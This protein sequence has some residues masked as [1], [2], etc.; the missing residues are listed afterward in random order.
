[1]DTTISE[2]AKPGPAQSVAT[3]EVTIE[4]KKRSEARYANYVLCVLMVVG[5]LN[6]LDRQI[7]SILIEDIKMDLG[8]SDGDMG[9]L[10]GTA[11]AVFY[12]T[13]GMALARLADV[14]NRKKLI[15]IG[16]GVWSVMT[17]LT[18]LAQNFTTLAV[19]RFGVGVGESCATPSSFSILYDCFPAKV[20]TT[21][22]GI[23]SCGPIVGGALGI[24]L[25]GT[26][27]DAWNGTWP[28]KNLAPLSLVGW[29]AALVIVGLPGVLVSFWVSTLREPVRGRYDGIVS[30]NHPHPFREA[31]IV[32]MSMLPICNLILLLKMGKGWRDIALNLVF[33]LLVLVGTYHLTMLTENV[34]QCAGL[35]IGFY[36]VFSWIQNLAAR[37]AVIFALIFRCKTTI[38][39]ILGMVT[40][41]LMMG[42][43]FWGV[44]FLQ[45]YHGASA[46][47]VGS[48]LGAGSLVA[49]IVGV[50]IGGFL[51]DK[52]RTRTGKGKLFVVIAGVVLTALAYWLL[53]N[54]EQLVV[55]YAAIILGGLT[56]SVSSIPMFSTIN[57]LMLPRGRATITAFYV[58]LVVLCGYAL[59]P[60]IVGLISDGL[61]ATGMESREALRQGMLW[62]LWGPVIGVGLLF[63]AVRHIEADEAS[64]L[65]RARA[66]GE[67][68]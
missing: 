55:A 4:A 40:S 36:A 63:Q 18:G 29:Q 30:A 9:F 7:M 10:G 49:G 22:L 53:L 48:V 16:L 39:V 3:T 1:M 28:D 59:V 41:M 51:S 14:W 37:D 60:Y 23:V 45:R 56:F 25:G 64:L 21:V 50:L 65:N 5:V 61:S 32:L 12:A 67:E 11:F 68:I 27:L 13:F 33:T 38:Y 46:S 2:I 34:V 26:L 31:A 20:R 44:P 35:A 52:L 57:D 8:L 66:L 58:M 6:Y 19:C 43:I 47:D 17:A 42:A 24:F 54:S 62:S 15:S